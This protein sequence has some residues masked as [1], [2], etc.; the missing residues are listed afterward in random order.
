MYNLT[1][2]LIF[3]KFQKASNISELVH[4]T[5]SLAA[6]S[7]R[8]HS[9][10][11][12]HVQ[13]SKKGTFPPIIS[14]RPPAPRSN[15][16]TNDVTELFDITA[17]VVPLAVRGRCNQR[18]HIVAYV[19]KKGESAIV[20]DDMTAVVNDKGR[21]MAIC[22]KGGTFYM[23]RALDFK[24]Y[25]MTYYR[26]E[27]MPRVLNAETNKIELRFPDLEAGWWC[28]RG[29]VRSM[30]QLWDAL[31]LLVSSGFW[32]TMTITHEFKTIEDE[33]AV[34]LCRALRFK[35]GLLTGMPTTIDLSMDAT[36]PRLE[37][38]LPGSDAASLNV[39]TAATAK[40]SSPPALKKARTL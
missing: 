15:R 6:L 33:A 40:K 1:H 3:T 29:D 10:R 18:A 30:P 37:A 38:E 19:L 17:N 32:P 31:M 11:R 8:S 34:A 16:D 22:I 9:P 12:R 21:I 36:E 14:G 39:A 13:M 35:E 7:L 23:R 27:D 20:D 26:I 25:G 2:N 24:L 5:Q 28:L 4:L